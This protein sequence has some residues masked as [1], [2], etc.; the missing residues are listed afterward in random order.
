MRLLNSD[1]WWLLPLILAPILIHLLIRQRLPRVRW[2]AMTFLLRALRKNRKKLLLETILLLIVRTAIVAAIVIVVLRPVAH[3]GWRWLAGQRQQAVGVI[4]LD[5]SAS[6]AASDGVRTRLDRAV[7][8]IE[9]YLDE[10]PSGSEVA[11]I[12]AAEPPIDLVRQP[13][14]DLG[15]VRQALS[16]LTARDSAAAIEDS[17]NRARERL[18]GQT[19]PN[20]EIVL[21]TDAQGPDWRGNDAKRGQAFA[22]AAD[23][24]KVFVLSVPETPS[25]DVAVTDL[26][27]AGGPDPDARI[28]GLATTL[29]PTSISITLASFN[30]REAVDTT[31]ELF[32]DGQKVARRQ[33]KVPTDHE[34]I[35]TFEHR[36][37][38]AGEHA[39][40]AR[41]DSDLYERDNQ[42]SMILKARERINALLVD[43]RPSP[44]PYTSA[45]GFLQVALWPTNPRDT[46]STSLFDTQVVGPSGLESLQIASFPLIILADVPALPTTALARIKAAVRDGAGLLVIAGAQVTPANLAA[47]FSEGGT[48]LLPVQLADPVN[49]PPDDPVIGMT[50]AQP[51]VP[52]LAGFDNSL[53]RALSQTGW[54]EH[55]LRPVASVQ[56]KNVQTWARFAR[57]GAALVANSFGRGR[58]VY[59]G[60]PADRHGGEFP[61]SPAFVPF[62]QQLAFYLTFGQDVGAVD[63]GRPMDW[64]VAA[65]AEAT[66]TYPDG[67]ST[68]A[69]AMAS[70]DPVTGQPRILLP[71]ADRAGVYSLS[72]TDTDGIPTRLRQAA[73]VPASKF[74]PTMLSVSALQDAESVRTAQVVPL[75]QPMRAALR[76]ARA[77]S[78]L[79]T[80][81]LLVLLALLAAELLLVKIFTPRKVDATAMLQKAMRL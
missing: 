41:C 56:G 38:S 62:I 36:F 49:L 53:L 60:A 59:F 21:V 72:V 70:E 14:R 15:Y 6:M 12:L 65:G 13:T 61:L 76:A 52:A 26:T 42:R 2:A 16:K 3:A 69:N 55:T 17:L 50:L 78:E 5:D 58:V 30:H 10:L 20:R 23:S 73:N 64:P 40:A 71:A 22:S 32:V 28:P 57:G 67:S 1:L 29:W 37:N 18:A 25:A 46:E 27:V 44:D 51:L 79:S 11:V 31:V 48:G 24:A 54:H 33:V 4:L 45:T 35:T 39:V 80:A 74:D 8:R 9:Q 7:A 66:L 75:D 47:M 34:F 81:G 63:A 68:P 43:G 19:S 77:E